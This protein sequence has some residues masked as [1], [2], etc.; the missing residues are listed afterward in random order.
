MEVAL[1]AATARYIDRNPNSKQLHES[2]VNYLPGGNT[3]TL[4]HTV[5]FPIS[6]RSGEGY[7]L[8]DEDGH[9]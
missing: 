8:Y 3:R 4:L 5:P 2:A 7:K 9:E 6:M 1:Q